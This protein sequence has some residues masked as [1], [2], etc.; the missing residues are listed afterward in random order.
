VSEPAGAAPEGI[1]V[2]GMAGRFPGAPDVERYWEGLV[3]GVESITF[4]DAAELRQAGVPAA[5]LEAPGYVRARAVLA[6]TDRF[7]ASFFGYSPREAEIMDPQH[8]LLLECACHALE[9]AGHDPRRYAGPVGVFAG[10]GSNTYLIEALTAHR[11]VLEAAGPYQAM[12]A[13]DDHFLATR[14]SYKLGLRGPSVTVQTACS[15]S[16]VAVHMAVQSLLNCE[17][18]MALAGG[19][20]VLV[21]QR[22]GY[23]YQAGGIFSP[24]GHCRPF[25]A[26]AQGAVDGEGVGLVVLK[27][28]ADARADGDRVHAVI[29]G[30]AINNDGAGKISYTAPSVDGQAEVVA[31]AMALAGAAPDSIGY[32]EGHGTATP[33]GDP[34][35]VAALAQAFRPAAGRRGFC[36]LGSVK[37]NIGHLDAAAGVAS[38]I[39]AVLAVERGI[40]PPTL[41]FSRPNPQIDLAASPFY[42]N[43]QPAAWQT[44][45]APRRAGVSSFGIGGTNAHLVLEEAVPAAAASAAS[46]GTGGPQ[47]LIVSA[48]AAAPLEAATAQLAAHLELHPELELADVAHTLQVGRTAFAHRRVLVARDTA[49]AA[50]AL[51]SLDPRRVLSRVQEPVNRPLAFLFPGQGA[52]HPGMGGELYGVALVFR[53]EVDRAAEALLPILG[54]DLRE[55]LWP[56]GGDA[57]A[58]AARLRQTALAQ[59]ALF[60][61]EHALARQ[62]EAWGVRP[63]AMLG[64]S[65]GEYVAACLS[66][67]FALEDALRLVAAR[68]R[69]MQEMPGGAMLAVPLAEAELL[70]LLGP[71]VA[72]AAV[73]TPALTVASGGAAEIAALEA[74]LASRGVEARRLHTSHAFHSAAMDEA[75]GRFAAVFAGVRLRPPA[76]PFVSNLTGTWIRPEEA[77]DPAYWAR[78]L[79]GCVRFSAGLERLFE[80]GGAVLLEVGPGRSL[81][82]LA[83]RHP[84]KPTGQRVLSSLPAVRP[85][86]GEDSFAAEG[87]G[88]RGEESAVL[89]T[90]GELWLAGV[91]VDWRGLHAERPRRRLALPGY[92]FERRRFWLEPGAGGARRGPAASAGRS[93]ASGGDPVAGWFWTPLWRQ[94]L[95]AAADLGP[96]D[97]AAGAA[98]GEPP[99]GSW[100]VLAGDDFGRRLARR[101]TETGRAVTLV[102]P[103]ERF[104]RGAAGAGGD[105]GDVGD[106]GEI[107][108]R[109][110]APEDYRAL[111]AAAGRPGRIVHAW[112]LAPE[113]ATNRLLDLGFYSLLALAHA[114][115][116][117]AAPDAPASVAARPAAGEGGTGAAATGA[118][119]ASPVPES[120]GAAAP[121]PRLHLGILTRGAQ[122][123]AGEA[124]L[125]PVQAT[126]LG[127][128][129][130]LPQELPGVSCQAIDLAPPRPGSRQETELLGRLLGEL[131]AAATDPVVAYR[132]SDRWVR[133]FEPV[134]LAPV[135]TV[136]AAGAVGVRRGGAYL[137]TGG[138]GGVGLEVAD[139]LARAGAAH[140]I[141]LGRGAFPPRQFWPALA[142]GQDAA[143]AAG[144]ANA[145]NVANVTGA[146]GRA[147]RLLAIEALGAR[148]LIVGADVADGPALRAA[149]AHARGEVGRIHG[150]FHAAGLPGGRL[151]QL[152]QPA[153][154]AAVL[155]PK[156]AGTLELAAALAE[157]EPD[158]LVLFSSLNAILG[159]P[160]QVDYA[161][162]NA[163]L[164][165]FAD[166]SILAEGPPVI[167]VDWDAW[168]GV[169]MLAAAHPAGDPPAAL[170]PAA[171][172]PPA[173]AAEMAAAPGAASH[174][175][176][177]IPP[178]TEAPQETEAT[179]GIGARPATSPAAEPTAPGNAAP[180][181]PAEDEG[182][183][184]G[185]GA[186]AAALPAGE[187]PAS[188]DATPPAVLAATEGA[189][190][191]PARFFGHPLFTGRAAAAEEGEG[192]AIYR[193]S[194]RADGTWVLDEHRLG[195]YPVVPGTAHLELAAA[196]FREWRA[197]AAQ[198]GAGAM[199]GAAPPPAAPGCELRNVAFLTPLA[200]ADGETRLLETVLRREAPR[201]AAEPGAAEEPG[202][203]TPAGDGGALA[204][205][206]RSRDAAGG[207]QDHATGTVAALPPASE[208]RRVDLA[209]LLAGRREESLGAGYR[210]ELRRAGLGP[211]WEGL[212]KVWV[213]AAGAVGDE[214]VVGLLELAPE[215]AA[216]VE[217]YIL[218]PALFDAA[219][220]FA[221]RW[222]AGGESDYLPLSYRRLRLHASLPRRFHS[223]A[224]WRAGGPAGVAAETLA[225]DLSLFD[226]EGRELAAVEEFTLK[227]V[228]AARAIRGQ[229]ERGSAPPMP[230]AAAQPPAGG[231]PPGAP[232]EALRRILGAPRRARIAVSVLSLPETIERARTLTMADLEE[233]APGAGSHERP[234]LSTPYLAPRT[235]LE[236]R[237]AALF[238]SVLGIERVGVHD[239]FFAL[240]GHSLLGTQLLARLRREMQVELPLARLFEAPTVADLAAGVVAELVSG[241]TVAVDAIP[242]AARA[243]DD[244]GD[245]PLSYAQ[246]RFWFLD[247]LEPAN[248]LYNV[249]QSALLEGALDVA[250]LARC[251]ADAAR[252]HETLRTLFVERDG[253]AVQ[254]VL[255]AAPPPRLP[256]VDLSALPAS[257]GG[258]AAEGLAALAARQAFDLTRL[259]LFAAQLY[260]LS[261]ERHLLALTMHHIISDGWSIGVLLGEM[262]ASYRAFAA[263]A[264][265]ALPALPVQYADYAVWQRERM[266]GP[267][268]MAELAA[269]LALLP[270][271][272]PLLD[273][274]TDRPRPA[275]R[276]FAGAS[277]AA[278]LPA[279]LTA[280]WKTFCKGE[281]ATLFMGLVTAVAV[282]LGRLSGQRDLLVGS[283][284]A[285]RIRPELEGLIGVFLNTLVLRADLGGNPTFRQLLGRLRAVT[286]EAYARQELPFAKLVQELRPRRD[287]SRTPVFEVL[288]NMQDFPRQDFALP[289]LRI[290]GLARRESAARFDLSFYAAEVLGAVQ[291]ELEHSTA[292][293]D[294]ATA[295]RWLASLRTL[296][297]A[298]AADPR[299]ADLAAAELP[300]LPAP[301]RRQLLLWSGAAAAGLPRWQVR[302][303]I[304]A[305]F[306]A[307]ARRTPRAIA[308][309]G[310]GELLTY[311]E[312]DGRS[313]ALAA[314][315]GAAGVGLETRVAVALPRGPRAIVALLA[316]LR[317]GG[318]YVP[319]DLAAPVDRLLWM[320][321][322][323]AV[324]VVL[325]DGAPRGERTGPLWTATAERLPGLRLIAEDD[326]GAA[327]GPAPLPAAPEMEL[328]ESLAYVL[329]TSGSSGLP[330]AV[331]VP[332]QAVL[333]LVAGDYVSFGPEQVWAQ[334]APLSFDAATLEIWGALLH[335]GRLE[336]LPD[337]ALEPHALGRELRRRGVTS[338]WL[339][340]GLFHLV[341]DEDL[342]AFGGLRQLLAGGDVLQPEAVRR[343]LA[344]HPGLRLVNGYGPTE[345]TTFTCCC[346]LAAPPAPGA[347]VPLGEP[348]AG[349][350]VHVLDERWRLAPQGAAG[351]LCA[352]GLGLARGYLGRPDLTAERFIPDP[353]CGERAGGDGCNDRN[354]G[355]E[356]GDRN[357]GSGRREPGARLYRTG[358]RV[359]FLPGGG[360]DFLGRIDRQVKIRGFRVEPEEV[361]AVLAAHPRVR[362][363]VVTVREDRA[364]D[365]RLVG[366]AV[367]D[368][369]AAPALTAAALVSYLGERLPPYLVPAALVLCDA[370]PLTPSG[371]VDRERL[372]A[373]P[374]EPAAAERPFAPPATVT[375]R[376]LAA[377]WQEVLGAARVGRDDR[378]FELGGHSLLALRAAARMRAAFQLDVPVRMLFETATLAELGTWVENE[379]IARADGAEVEALLAEMEALADPLAGGPAGNG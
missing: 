130:V 227:R 256:L 38:L 200:V 127:P 379:A 332:Q 373:P 152:R 131:A 154:A 144:V 211:R 125:S 10:C 206:T 338:L 96:L 222:A 69:L 13:S 22:A 172:A 42:V 199:P 273:L 139:F 294:G 202:G 7:D 317:A 12:L 190:A 133:V 285:G 196:A 347:A 82:A 210:E 245:L 224:R 261:A 170:E 218:H 214:G 291:L 74:L 51:R 297:E 142:G 354:G 344:A 353:L 220:S 101:L 217:S 123:V 286:L 124:T 298:V 215:L 366:Y 219:T 336:V 187:P 302:G 238:G 30:S 57:A 90:L 253:G 295:A 89:Q 225:F 138:L 6:Q 149:L 268:L 247:R 195:G 140:L 274:P 229:A 179:P 324:S 325:T 108:L 284:V 147:R 237:L 271:P 183:A 281:S 221:Q 3:A 287:P 362:A 100:W 249:A 148:I 212:R 300:L 340:A 316:V 68:G 40:I 53:R 59:P 21:P 65:V 165:A 34:I 79:R 208:P 186:R 235:P 359:R 105:V 81:A 280:A 151:A 269:T 159:G 70:P 126:V 160:G 177:P 337:E 189:E 357:G 377:I 35:E 367:P 262:A 310:A 56:A 60:V 360:F 243:A 244:R 104:R 264:P 257:R 370:L 255:A 326:L 368:A 169:G 129:M 83:R 98:G 320:L 49:E 93:L 9:H 260:R 216:D 181:A 288:F 26:A 115:A 66:G 213:G 343:T 109:P 372:P 318:A 232:I 254:R 24:D 315:L 198:R 299:Q 45:A 364:G 78:Q 352:G 275:V 1:A 54:L 146:A 335:G 47:V 25:D 150:A 32:V 23:L 50:A 223:H 204:F 259:P 339:T 251:L 61:V 114:L 36:A 62:W 175:G 265:A 290:T 43:A 306:A 328:G 207:W 203:G 164:G 182:A 58:A 118:R 270:A 230:L 348:I 166:A 341:A 52:Q 136:P 304:A 75:A 71:G 311:A 2:I 132:G 178:K 72:L 18:D 8:R 128:A 11:E 314:R 16:L 356:R 374:E 307:Q 171:W 5:L 44:G 363:A 226:D 197:A 296:L 163:F 194:L 119:S 48:A 289:G 233:V 91:E 267:E 375:E 371:K 161:A 185:I 283:P 234:D 134:D 145:A 333:R 19:V 39:K 319:L 15:S 92:P 33:L 121:P 143:N 240:G 122:R 351:E 349:T 168:Q 322:D 29:L 28:L 345:N 342:A 155:A 87:S 88:G 106:V 102:T 103:G 308:L 107:E 321:E 263:A 158:F 327:A 188:G 303:T 73:N 41:H 86:A 369:A 378:F 27:R 153:D 176:A 258:A 248:P 117:G 14:I 305:R 184:P 180:A 17:C 231:M 355:G 141:L 85:A 350:H 120:G 94:T 276:G 330:K 239:D 323:A 246:E 242:R 346:P 173:A 272:L 358:D 80:R 37:G 111:L 266:R 95:P 292:L 209:A 112:S 277:T 312:L 167:A 191:T 313:A 113:T 241:A 329:Y 63:E 116:E 137:I 331:A 293:F 250:L 278:S 376:R 67:V 301:E 334:L 228:D 110:G 282:L 20:R 252:R 279:A 162:A 76:I 365:R 4:F 157:D 174:P 201:A 193:S 84:G 205:A 64:H 99:E 46:A 236:G 77:T 156:V 31:M 361:E 97:P 135:S 55:A 192:V 309:A